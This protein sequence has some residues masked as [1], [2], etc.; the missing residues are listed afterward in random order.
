MTAVGV[1]ISPR[2]VGRWCWRVRLRACA[3][4]RAAKKD[5]GRA[6]GGSS[7]LRPGAVR[8]SN[9]A[10]DCSAT[11]APANGVSSARAARS[12]STARRSPSSPSSSMA[13]TRAARTAWDRAVATRRSMAAGV[14][15]RAR[16]VTA[17]TARWASGCV[18][19]AGEIV[20]G[21][22]VAEQRQAGRGHRRHV[23]VRVAGEFGQP[24]AGVPRLGVV[25]QCHAQSAE[26]GVRVV[27]QVSHIDSAGRPEGDQPLEIG[28]AGLRG[29]RWRPSGASTSRPA[30]DCALST[31]T[32]HT[33]T[34]NAIT[35]TMRRFCR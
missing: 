20:D 13:C 28:E 9:A 25:Q 11:V 14:R 16:A 5:T 22:G 31:M 21:S 23:R 27:Q 26:R 33:A 19:Q 8:S 10:T 29:R 18:E 1:R 30:T 3:G 12:V 24:G 17:R 4:A 15:R 34:I 7:R 2:A 32:N 35:A 6:G